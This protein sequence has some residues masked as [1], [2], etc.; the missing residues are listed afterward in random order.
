MRHALR[1]LGREQVV[2]LNPADSGR[3]ALSTHLDREGEEASGRV[4]LRPNEGVVIRLG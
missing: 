4:K 2:D 1:R 3:I